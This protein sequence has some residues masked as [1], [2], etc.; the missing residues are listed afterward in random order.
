MYLTLNHYNIFIFYFNLPG[1][2]NGALAPMTA[3]EL[4]AV[5]VREALVRA[6]VPASEVSEVLLGQVR[7]SVCM[8]C[9][10]TDEFYY[11]YFQLYWEI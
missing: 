7:H 6:G 4:G 8:T 2:F 11:L 3:H 5:V 9:L 10:T 1:S